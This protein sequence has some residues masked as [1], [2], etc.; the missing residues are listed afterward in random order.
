MHTCSIKK[1]YYQYASVV[2]L[3]YYFTQTISL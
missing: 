3:L 1:S 2:V